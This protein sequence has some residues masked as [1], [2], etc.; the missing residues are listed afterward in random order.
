MRIQQL[1]SD[2]ITT[3]TI[4]HIYHRSVLYQFQITYTYQ[5]F[6]LLHNLLIHNKI[7]FMTN[8]TFWFV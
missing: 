4:P 1:K 7:I 8:F 6:F 2:A 3:Q 5:Q